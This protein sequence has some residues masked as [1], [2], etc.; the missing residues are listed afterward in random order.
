MLTAA[1]VLPTMLPTTPPTVLPT[2]PPAGSS[3][4]PSIGPPMVTSGRWLVP[5]PAVAA[6]LLAVLLYLN[7]LDNPFVYDDY[8]LI[9]ENPT[10]QNPSSL[11]TILSR[12]ITRPVVNLTYAIDTA[13]WGRDP[14]GYHVT[15][16]AL[17]VVNVLLVYWVALLASA[18]RARQRAQH[19][20]RTASPALAATVAAVLFATHPMMT[21]AVGYISGR[22]EVAYAASFLAAFLAGRRWM[23][24]G[25]AVWWTACVALWCLSM[26]TKET[27]AM[28]PSVLIAYDR[29]VLEAAPAEHRRRLVRLGGPMLALMILVAAL[30]LAVLGGVE[31]QGQTGLDVGFGLVAADAFWRYVGL[32]VMPSQQSIF[33][34]VPFLPSVWAPRAL[35]GLIGLGVVVAFVWAVRRVHSV[36]ALGLC[37]FLLLLV[38][39]SVL[40]SFGVGEPLAE[41]RA[42]LAA[43]GLFLVA[44]CL[45]AGLW[46]RARVRRGTLVL[47]AVAGL[48]VAQLAGRTL[49]R[50]AIW[51]DPVVLARES[52]A[53]AP[54]HWIPQLLLAETERQAG[55]CGMA[56]ASYAR[57]IALRPI[58]PFAYLGFANCLIATGRVAEAERALI[59]MRALDPQSQEA[60]M[61]LGVLAAAQNRSAEARP[62]FDEVLRRD[63]SRQDARRFMAFLDGGLAKAEHDEL[64]QAMRLL[65]T[66]GVRLE[67]CGGD[68]VAPVAQGR[69][70]GGD[71]RGGAG[72][73]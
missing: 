72:G 28:L 19:L 62:Y 1:P 58:E 36:V 35:G 26:M 4:P 32:F 68:P 53:L 57:A 37:W 55:R 8:R 11:R 63:P 18:D 6:A 70:A 20:A 42:Y 21:Q 71:S 61:G 64:C 46:A 38:P 48:L 66:G 17:H 73:R 2:T 47:G 39:S 5:L 67:R 43:V 52:V 44:G 54:H 25:G 12:D 33:H 65:A 69:G 3:P 10:I 30:R 27:G 9:V 16:L 15:S 34:D 29:F 24:G 59:T 51:D 23:I 31:Y 60:A 22:S 49:L 45:F 14:F 50:N 41:H 7:A 56:V 13:L 40:F